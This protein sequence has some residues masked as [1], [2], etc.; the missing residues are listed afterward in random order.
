MA[1]SQSVSIHVRRKVTSDDLQ[2]VKALLAQDKGLEA[3]DLEPYR[4]VVV[5]YCDKRVVVA[6][7][8]YGIGTKPDAERRCRMEAALAR[9]I[10]ALGLDVRLSHRIKSALGL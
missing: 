2:G 7:M 8:E 10:E 3:R 1:V 6:W 9:A 4:P 5:S